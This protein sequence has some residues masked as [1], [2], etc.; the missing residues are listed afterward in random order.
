M[1]RMLGPATA[2]RYTGG[3]TAVIY[4]DAAG[5]QLAD[6]HSY[7]AGVAVAG[8]SLTIDAGGYLPRFYFPDGVRSVWYRLDGAAPVALT[9][10]TETDDDLAGIG[11]DVSPRTHAHG[12]QALFGGGTDGVVDM[13]G[14]N[15]YA[16]FAGLVGTVYTLTRD[17]LASTLTV[18]AGITLCTAGFRVYCSG[19]LTTEATGVIHN[20]GAA[21]VAGAAGAAAPG[22]TLTAAVAG[23]A[24]GAGGGAGAAGTAVA[25]SA[26]GGAG[27]AGGAADAGG[28]GGAGGAVTAPTA[29]FGGLQAARVLQPA[30]TGHR[31]ECWSCPGHGDRSRGRRRWCRWCQRRRWRWWWRWCVHRQQP[32][33]GQRRGDHGDRWCRC[34]RDRGQ[35]RWWRWWWR[36]SGDRQHDR[37]QWCGHGDGRR[38]RPGRQGRHGHRWHGWVCWPGCHQ[39]L[40]L[41]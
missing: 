27:G 32:T 1:A 17:V 18:R 15:A 31:P 39:R 21:A 10:D 4:S 25:A 40:G 33:A 36:W 16:A 19:T 6:I 28:A 20:N 8:S 11:S 7:P 22:G 23:G 37:C 35:R 13:D 34:G 41:T 9:P 14:V 38:R 26:F 12:L 30:T 29:A 2:Q 3:T 5:I 24:G